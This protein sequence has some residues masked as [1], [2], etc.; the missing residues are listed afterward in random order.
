M[1]RAHID[2]CG[3]EP[4]RILDV[5]T[6]R[7]ASMGVT[8][9]LCFS[10]DHFAQILEGSTAALAALMSAIRT[11]ARH[12]MLREW[13]PREAADGRRLFPAWAMGYTHDDRLDR[14]MTQMVLEDHDIPLD[15]VAEVLFAG[16]EL[17][18]AHPA[19]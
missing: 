9:L 1:S 17:Y 5:A 14:A 15:M 3:E 7:N 13:Q 4:R 10:G 11:D 6:A 16:L 19:A 8:G 2:P 18:Q 12:H